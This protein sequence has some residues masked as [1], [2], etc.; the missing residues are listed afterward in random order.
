MATL[1]VTGGTGQLAGALE[2]AGAA[3]RHPARRAA[4]VRFRP[5]RRASTRRSSRRH[6]GAGGQRRRLH[7]GRCGGDRRR[8]RRTGPTTSGRRVWRRCAPAAGVPLIHVSTDYVFD[9][10]K[11]APYVETD[12]T[13]PPGV[14]GATKLA[15]EQAV[16][17]SGAQAVMLRTSWV[18]APSGRNFVRTMLNAGRMR[19]RAARGRRPEGLPDHRARPRRRDPGD[20]RPRS[21]PRAGRTTSAACS[22]PPA[23]AGRPGTA[24]PAPPSRGGRP[25]AR[26]EDP[27]RRADRHRG[28]AHTGPPAGQFA[29]RLRQT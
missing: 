12:P 20:R 27:D 2:D 11:G 4:G 8:G 28:L 16:L 23:P 15:G 10:A 25:R 13:A 6:P 7:R 5:R 26:A 3:R 22:M 1:L 17:A 29:A 19:D 9:G 14:Y 21:W 18:Y 24:W